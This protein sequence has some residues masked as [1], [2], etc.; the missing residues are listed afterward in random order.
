MSSSPQHEPT[1]EEILAS[2]RKIISEDSTEA[3]PAPAP[4]VEP[5]PAPVAAAAASVDADV[6]ELTQEVHEAA[7]QPIPNPAPEPEPVRA[8]VPPE[9]DVVFE[10]IEEPSVT[11]EAPVSSHEDIFSDKTRRAME[12]TFAHI[13]P[14]E[15]EAPR[16]P[17]ASPVAPI[18]G[19]TVEA[20]FERAVREAFDP[21]VNNWLGTNTDAVVDR[22]KP[23]IREW[24]DD[25]F[26][27]LLEG[28]VRNEVAR[29][30]KARGTKR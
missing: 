11:S 26:P 15:E 29:V 8:V 22:M 27:A 16:R 28:A 13:E 12:D 9:N 23:L 19:R 6:L 25:H 30:V 21:V 10:T 24:M 1:M 14:E 2:I 4:A 17:A 7:P 18:D 5:K 3:Q 20:V